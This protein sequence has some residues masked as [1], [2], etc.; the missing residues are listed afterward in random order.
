MVVANLGG[1]RM[2]DG[3]PSSQG[4]IDDWTDLVVF[5]LFFG[6]PLHEQQKSS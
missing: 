2:A 4:T 1:K 3:A 5:V 6:G